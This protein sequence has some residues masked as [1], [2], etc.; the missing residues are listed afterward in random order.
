MQNIIKQYIRD[1]KNNPRGVTVAVRENNEVFYGF[2]LYNPEDKYDKDRG[3]KI[4]L[5]R[6]T[7]PA[8]QLPNVPDRLESVLKAYDDLEARALKYFK[9]LTY[10]QVALGEGFRTLAPYTI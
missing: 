5:A 7:A 3:L 10:D 4:A 6:A 2:A 8:Y 9:D 1:E